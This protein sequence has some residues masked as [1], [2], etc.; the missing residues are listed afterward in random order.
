VGILYAHHFE[1]HPV[2]EEV[3]QSGLHYEFWKHRLH[4]DDRERAEAVLRAALRDNTV[5]EDVFRV[6]LPGGRVRHI[7]A[8]AVTELDA[9]GKPWRVVGVNRDITAQRE[10]EAA[11]RESER[12]Y[13]LI[14]ESMQDVVWVLDMRT[15]RFPYISPSIETMTGYTPAEY[16]QNPIGAFLTPEASNQLKALL[17][18]RTAALL[19][20][21]TQ[22]GHAYVDEVEHP[23]KDGRMIATEV[24]MT[25]W[26]NEDTGGVEVRGVS[27][28]ISERKRAQEELRRA[29]QQ[30]E[31][32][33]QAKSA[34]LASMSHEIRT[35]MNAVLGL[36]QLLEQEPLTT[37]QH[38][39]LR[40]IREAGHTLLSLINDILDFSKIEA[41]QLRM[42][43]QPF[44]LS[45]I[46]QQLDHLLRHVADTKG[47]AL[48]IEAPPPG[49]DR[50]IADAMRLEQVLV[51]LLNNAIKF[52]KAGEV[53]LTVTAAPSEGVGPGRI[54]LRFAVKDT[55]IGISPEAQAKLFQSFS[56]ADAS[57]TRRF[58]GTG[59]GLAISK[60]IVE[61]MGGQIGVESRPGEG[62]AFWV[63]IPLEVAR[64]DTA[65][66]VAGTEPKAPDGPR[67]TGLRVLAVDDNRINLM[68][69]E[70]ALRRQGATVQHAA[71]GQEALQILEMHPQGF[72]VVLMDIQM[73]VMDGLAATRA[74][75]RNPVWRDLPVIALTA[76]VLAEER[77]AA[78]QAGMNDFLAKPLDLDRMNALLTPYVPSC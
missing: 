23:H 16:V 33:S 19:A 72:D 78:E 59:L 43:P 18:Q 36:A 76:G 2:P 22:P 45:E 35:P 29:K 46:L 9:K 48:V 74:I 68:V 24:V 49:P 38:A 15:L 21:Q 39:M 7:Q 1:S 73:P 56:Q 54:V 75:R 20:G 31:G 13:R 71:D 60:R 63:A 62:S 42:D 25:F 8:A 11:L 10:Q 6:S 69:L 17:H 12:K 57:I 4:S 77:E 70:K 28:D 67:L 51:N 50:F 14:T 58:G 55:G 52:T 5:Y 37:S 26:L 40:H 30:A 44:S 66:P 34:F 65:R 53:R 61:L 27:R 32:A 41:G 3:R 47:L 64:E